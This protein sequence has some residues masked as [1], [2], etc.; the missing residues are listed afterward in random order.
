MLARVTYFFLFIESEKFGV[1]FS[2]FGLE[3]LACC[4]HLKTSRLHSTPK[5]HVTS[6]ENCGEVDKACLLFYSLPFYEALSS[7]LHPFSPSLPPT[8]TLS[9]LL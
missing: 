3:V 7:F 2:N 5:R 9:A 6:E 1:I 8:L 4:L